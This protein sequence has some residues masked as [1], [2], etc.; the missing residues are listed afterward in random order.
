[1]NSFNKA[2]YLLAALGLCLH[3]PQLLADID[4]ATAA[5][6]DPANPLVL[7][8]TARGDIYIEL[9]PA[10]A[11]ENVA[12]V[13]ALIRGEIEIED[14]DNGFSFSP[15]YYDGMRFHRVIPGFVIQTGAPVN[16]PLGDPGSLL[17]NEINA[18][19]LGLNQQ[20]VMLDN[21]DLNPILDINNRQEFEQQ[22]LTPLYEAMG[23]SDEAELRRQQNRVFER[24]Q[25]LSIKNLYE[26]QGYRY[27]SGLPSRPIRRGIVALANQGPAS[28]G[29]EFFIALT[30]SPSLDGKYTVIG[31]VTEGLDV[32]DSIGSTAINPE[33]YS[34]LSTVIYSARQVN[35]SANPG[36][37][38]Q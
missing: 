38:Q 10:E 17:A 27:R 11:P 9:L 29:P 19:S 20:P 1:M 24:L 13:L 7:F 14:P 23:I 28:N 25:N 31:R 30:D 37:A 5:M 3:S 22:V 6:E 32:A 16:H 26:L 12:N 15:N 8:D 33:R 36:L 18:D 21:G 34:R 35:G 4:S 2:F